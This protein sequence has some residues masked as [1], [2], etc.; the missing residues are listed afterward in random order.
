M[1][2][3]QVSIHEMLRQE[4]GSSSLNSQNV[5]CVN[6]SVDPLDGTF[7]GIRRSIPPTTTLRN[8]LAS[9]RHP[10]EMFSCSPSL[11]S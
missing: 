2:D 8:I 5:A 3:N 11:R 10:A 6:K 7:S 4:R 1:N 9:T